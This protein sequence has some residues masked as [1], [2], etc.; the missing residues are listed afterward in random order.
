MKVKFLL[1]LIVL[2]L[3]GETQIMYTGRIIELVNVGEKL[4]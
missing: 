2:K 3:E 4:Q 1:N